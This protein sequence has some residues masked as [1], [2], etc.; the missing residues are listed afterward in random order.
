MLTSAAKNKPKYF[1]VWYAILLRRNYF[2]FFSL[3]PPP[4]DTGSPPLP[5]PQPV[6]V[7]LAA[8]AASCRGGF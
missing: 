1:V 6:V 5:L 4:T 3:F 8:P 2:I 7:D